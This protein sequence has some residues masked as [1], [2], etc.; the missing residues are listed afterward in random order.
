[1][2]YLK[3]S[4]ANILRVLGSAMYYEVATFG[5]KLNANPFYFIPLCYQLNMN[6]HE[7]QNKL[8][9]TKSKS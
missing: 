2:L 7:F 4:F 5:M 6:D 9:L 3:I 8:V 1:M